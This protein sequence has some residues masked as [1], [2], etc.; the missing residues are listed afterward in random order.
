ML[1]FKV[2]L[3]CRLESFSNLGIFFTCILSVIFIEYILAHEI[4]IYSINLKE[5]IFLLHGIISFI[6]LIELILGCFYITKFINSDELIFLQNFN[7]SKLDK[8]SIFFIKVLPINFVCSIL[9]TELMYNT[10]IN[11]VYLILNS[12]LSLIIIFLIEIIISLFITKIVFNEIKVLLL[13][14]LIGA[15]IKLFYR[16]FIYTND[17]RNSI[18][19]FLI[20][21]SKL[22]IVRF[23]FN[24][25]LGYGLKQLIINLFSCTILSIILYFIKDSD[26]FNRQKW[27]FYYK[28]IYINHK[29]KNINPVLAFLIKDISLI[30][31]YFSFIILEIIF[32]CFSIFLLSQ[33]SIKNNIGIFIIIIVSIY[34]F[35]CITPSIFKFEEKSLLLIKSFPITNRKFFIYKFISAYIISTTI[36]IL[37]LFLGLIFLKISFLQFLQYLLIAIAVGILLCLTWSCIAY[38]FFPNVDKGNVL[39]TLASVLII[40]PPIELLILILALKLINNKLHNIEV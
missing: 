33:V 10:Y 23:I 38:I 39:L 9:Y 34:L 8:I 21:T 40:F 37:I 11:C 13:L 36:P 17:I 22:N 6:I 14:I 35:S 27:F 28:K 31:Q 4:I 19:L 32:V 25:F 12:I 18:T 3:R 29:L 30:K 16:G 26:Y 1:K 15:F 2:Y 7:L 20:Y 24:N 5:K